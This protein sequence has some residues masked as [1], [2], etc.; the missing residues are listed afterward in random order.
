R[1]LYNGALDGLSLSGDR[2]FY[3][4]PLASDGRHERS[5]WFGTA[6]CPS[7]IARLVASVGNYIYARSESTLWVNLFV[8]SKTNVK[9][10]GVHVPVRLVTEYPWD[11]KVKI[12][13]EPP[14]KVTYAL[15]IRIPGWAE[16]TA[17]PGGLYHFTN[18]SQSSVRITLNGKPVKVDRDRGYAV[19]DRTWEKGDAVELEF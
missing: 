12:E 3:G 11:G 7:N 9:F 6:C 15:R 14:K 17:V 18:A 5:A 4:N 13:V 2:F 1:S 16:N 10:K 8:D 19:I